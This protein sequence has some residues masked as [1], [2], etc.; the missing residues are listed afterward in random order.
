MARLLRHSFRCRD[1]N[2]GHLLHD[3]ATGTTISVDAPEETPLLAALAERGWTLTHI[4]TTHHHGDHVAANHALQTRFGCRIIGPAAEEAEIPDVSQ[5]VA[6]GSRLDLAGCAI[7]VLA[8]PGHTRGHVAYYLPTERL[9]LSGDA[10]FALG[11]G[12]V[13]EGSLTEMFYSVV[14]FASLPAD[15]ALLCGH[16]Y[17]WSNARFALSVEPENQALQARAAEFDAWKAEA[18]L[19]PLS[20]LGAERAANPFLRANSPEIRRTLGLERARDMEV[21]AE[22]RRRKD[23]F[24]T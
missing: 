21:F 23:Q 9:L 14:Q 8:C 16:D 1:D 13:F 6:G 11:C 24:R 3:P 17:G 19:A 5:T 10:L 2:Y 4:L 18:R 22:L 12:R 20:T 7:E 15:T